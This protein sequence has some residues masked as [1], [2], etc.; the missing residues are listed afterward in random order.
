MAVHVHTRHHVSR[1]P[2]KFSNWFTIIQSVGGE[3]WMLWPKVE[4]GFHCC[5]RWLN[6]QCSVYIYSCMLMI[7][8]CWRTTRSTLLFSNVIW[9]DF[10]WW[11]LMTG[12]IFQ[13]EDFAQNVFSL[14]KQNITNKLWFKN[15]FFCIIIQDELCTELPN[16][17]NRL[18]KPPSG[19]LFH[20]VVYCF[21]K[22]LYVKV[23][24]MY[25][26]KGSN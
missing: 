2:G 17:S 4:K 13:S 26:S 21:F 12:F 5:V 22:D 24:V 1:T 25:N 23:N 3:S 18:E 9:V 7:Q 15:H 19:V 20:L 10:I 11:Y 16:W 6:S 14:I 8:W